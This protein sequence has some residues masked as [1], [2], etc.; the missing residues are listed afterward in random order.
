MSLQFHTNH[1]RLFG[2]I[3]FGFI[4]LTALIAIG[5][6]AW[7]QEQNEPLP[8]LKDLSERELRGLAVYVAEGCSYC[9]TQQVRPLDVDRPFGRPSAPGDYAHLRPQDLWRM[10]PSLLGT[11]RTGPDLSDLASRLPSESWNYI[12]LFNPR[13]VVKG[14][15][16]QAYPWLFEIRSSTGPDDVV[17]AVPPAYAPKDG[18]VVAKR[19]AMD[20]VAYLLTLRQLPFPEGGAAAVHPTGVEQKEVAPGQGGL[21]YA[22][23]CAGC[24]GQNGEGVAGVFPPLK[25]DPVVLDSDPE[26]HIRVVLFGLQGEE[27]NGTKYSAAMPGFED[28]LSDDEVAAVVNHERMSWGNTA[29][30]TTAQEVAKVRKKGK[31]GG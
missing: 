30:S 14:S 8:G 31:N 2:A 4:I 17:V 10:T 26:D 24:H 15:I 1:R 5:P 27:I 18:K 9:H 12:H 7:V 3:F 16:M 11:E 23:R 13:A 21:T 22:T 28:G 20:L 25:G 29:S 19:E 6:A